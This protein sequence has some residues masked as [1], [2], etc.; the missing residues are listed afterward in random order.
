M[1]PVRVPTSSRP[2]RL[3]NS[4][5]LAR[6]EKSVLAIGEPKRLRSRDHLRFVAAQA[7]LVC[8]R[9]PSQA[10]TCAGTQPRAM[11]RKVSDELT[12]PVC[13]LHHHE[14]HMRGNECASL[15]QTVAI[16]CLRGRPVGGELRSAAAPDQNRPI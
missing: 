11:G 12:V 14:L 13:A 4:T 1:L 8:G 9:I 5:G 15:A 2:A 6:I 7:C 10:T 3:Q 16:P